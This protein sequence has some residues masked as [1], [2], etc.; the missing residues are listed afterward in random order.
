MK[1]RRWDFNRSAWIWLFTFSSK[2]TRLVLE[3]RE[4]DTRQ[5]MNTNALR[6]RRLNILRQQILLGFSPNA[7]AT[8]GLIQTKSAFICE[9]YS[10]HWLCHLG[11]SCIDAL[12]Q[13]H[14]QATNKASSHSPAEQNRLPDSSTHR[15]EKVTVLVSLVTQK[16]KERCR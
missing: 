12:W 7:N 2:T 9:D 1:S 15:D 10:L 16:S 11:T 14:V 6:L 5:H 8:V 3:S 13:K 4:I